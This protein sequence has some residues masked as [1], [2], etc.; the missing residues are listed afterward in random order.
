MLVVQ[1]WA[2]VTHGATNMGVI[3]VLATTIA[4][5]YSCGQAGY[6]THPLLKCRTE[7]LAV[8]AWAAVTHGTTNMDV[9]V[10]LATTIAYTYSCGVVLARQPT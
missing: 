4:Y 10:V 8:Q 2:V 6:P 5:T 1:A 3:L 9:L 7:M